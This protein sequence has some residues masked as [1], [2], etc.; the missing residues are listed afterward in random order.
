VPGKSEAA[1][2]ESGPVLAANREFY[3]AFRRRDTEAMERLWAEA[4]GL[5]CIHPGW[6]AL[7][8]RSEI[9]ESWRGILE[10]PDSPPITCEEESVRFVGDAAIVLCTEMIG[11]R[12]LVATNVFVREGGAWRLVLHQATPTAHT[13]APRK[14]ETPKTLH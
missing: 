4:A 3:R 7:T 13:W 8:K 9:L 2:D 12:A 5:V 6:E 11:G 14:A 10:S 1:A